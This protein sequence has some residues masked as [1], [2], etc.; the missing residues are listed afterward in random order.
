MQKAVSAFYNE[1][2]TEKTAEEK[3]MEETDKTDKKEQRNG[4]GEEWR[5]CA[6]TGCKNCPS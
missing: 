5:T 3:P 1:V 4:T 2:M 6:E